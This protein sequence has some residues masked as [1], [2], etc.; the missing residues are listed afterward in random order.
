VAV[1]NSASLNPPNAITLAA[2]YRPESFQG[3]GFDPV[4]EK[5]YIAHTY[6]YYQYKLGVTGDQYGHD[7]AEFGFNVTA[8]GVTYGG[9][10]EEHF[11]TPGTWYFLT[12]TYDGST[13]KLYVDG[14][15]ID[16]ETA[17]GTITDYGT[18]V[19]FGKPVHRDYYLRG[20]IDELRIYN[21]ALSE[22]EIQ[23][24]YNNQLLTLI[25]KDGSA[26]HN[27]IA[28][29]SFNI[30]KVANDPPTMSETYLGELTTDG[31]GKIYLPPGWF[32]QGEW[33]KVEKLIH[34]FPALK[35][36]VPLPIMYY[37]K[38][39]NGSFDAG[40]GAI[41]YYTLSA[42]PEQE[43]IVDH[44]TVMFDL[45][46]SVEWDADQQYLD[47]LLEGFRL[48]S[49]YWYDISDGQLY[50]NK[51]RIFDNKVNW[52]AAD[53][54]IEARNNMKSC[55]TPPRPGAFRLRGPI[56]LGHGYISLPRILYFNED[57]ANINLTFTL[58]PYDWTIAQTSYTFPPPWGTI[59]RD[60]PPSRVLAHEF[61]HYGIGF[62]DEYEDISGNHVFPG[63]G[64]PVTP[65]YDFGLMDDELK[66]GEV[67]NS[68]ISCTGIQYSDP[69]QQVTEQ[70]V[71]RG[72]RSCW[73]YFQWDFEGTYPIGIFAPIKI[74]I[75]QMFWGPNDDLTQPNYDVGR[76][77]PSDDAI[78]NYDGGAS[79][80]IATVT[81]QISGQPVPVADVTLHK[82][83]RADIFE[84][85]TQ[86]TGQ[87]Q[88]LGYNNGDVATSN[89]WSVTLKGVKVW[90]YG[91][92]VLGKSG[93]SGFHN[94]YRTSLDGDTLNISL[95]QVHGSYPLIYTTSLS[96]GEPEF[97]IYT[98][99]PF[100]DNP[101]LELHPDEN[102]EQIYT[103]QPTPTGYSTS[104]S[105]SMGN[106]G[107]FTL[108]A[109][110]DSAYTF[111]VNTP[112][113]LTEMD[114][115][116][117]PDEIT[118]PHGGC[119]LHLDTLNSS[120]QKVIILSSSYPPIRTGLPPESEQAGEIYS[121]SS[122]PGIALL[123]SNTLILHY[124]E[125]DLQTQP[126]ATL[127]VFKW[128]EDLQTW[129][130]LCGFLDTEHNIIGANINSLGIYGAFTVGYL[131]GDANGSGLVEL[132]DVVYLIT[133]L[134]KNGPAP[135]PLLAGDANC[136]GEV[137]LGDV[138]YLISYLYKAGPPPSCK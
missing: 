81:D 125:N 123:G 108:L 41:S 56:F 124:K 39:D 64:P 114:D 40:T 62:R 119:E 27:P 72:N 83:D 71:D 24:L 126:E 19:H 107:R 32:A 78:V 48:M 49:N 87:I 61:G 16:Q 111:F 131:R 102:P 5:A 127:E 34:Y 20:T 2:W 86:N 90:L 18:P 113:C 55:A 67:Q 122:Y 99:Q 135:V 133:Y 42:D 28:N 69:A 89:G 101:S 85:W 96:T 97:I 106:L 26:S 70:W 68:E 46:V 25:L 22:A 92:G 29:R 138:V 10:T 63:Q 94:R 50:I 3:S 65:D 37:I 4:I 115:T 75:A 1:P 76:L 110:D 116:T 45:L 98:V 57:W 44:T 38:L 93:V 33:V 58:Y 104:I 8:G 84:G 43:V 109:S 77:I 129:E 51:V 132:G 52:L 9:C 120:L 118:G 100:S 21:R 134:Y 54:R 30:Y 13:A 137:E 35:H 82:V 17:S 60:Y 14:E 105:D 121:L 6:P 74:P 11:W 80:R 130:E 47:N 15:L 36:I 53:I 59:N 136:S 73:D 128:D 79:T 7:E 91:E 66:Q 23:E 31:N 112:Y 12:G 117:F 103:L 88:C 95:V